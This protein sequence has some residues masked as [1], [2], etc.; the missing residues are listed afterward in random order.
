M[1]KSLIALCIPAL[2]FGI[3]RATEGNQATI[4]DLDSMMD[5]EMDKVET[6]PDFVTPPAGTYMLSVTDCK[7]E[8]YTP[9]ATKENTKPTE[10]VRIKLF[11]Q[12]DQTIESVDLPVKDG[13]LFSESFMFTEDGLKY[14]KRQAMNI[15]NVPDF[16]GA[17]LRDVIDG[18]K[19]AAFKAKITI[20]KTANPAGGEY[21]NVQVRP[22]HE[23]PTA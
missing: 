8:K 6:L 13:S 23:A 11:Y 1:N 18:V 17:K 3:L 21:E 2:S 4:L 9:K 7:T 10:A 12:V 16:E 22:V 15:L 5:M 20:R 19:G 14:F